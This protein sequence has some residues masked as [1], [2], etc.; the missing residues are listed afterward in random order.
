MQS[1]E[2]QVEMLVGAFINLYEREGEFKAQLHGRYK[3]HNKI[4]TPE[5][6]LDIFLSFL[7]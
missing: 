5:G 4:T 6:D 2:Q 1:K 3:L 7:L